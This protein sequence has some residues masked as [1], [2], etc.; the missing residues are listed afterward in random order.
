[1]T[2]QERMIQYRAKERI[3]QTELAE[4]CG[5]SYQTINSVEN[6][7]QDPSKVTQAKIELVINE[8]GAE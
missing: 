3:S 2:L 8:K 6:G 4:R 5:V 7:T 1:M